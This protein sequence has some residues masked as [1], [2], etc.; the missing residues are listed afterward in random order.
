MPSWHD[1]FSYPTASMDKHRLVS[2]SEGQNVI[3][4][5]NK[6]ITTVMG[7]TYI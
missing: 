2:A 6:Q 5:E 7:I 4:Q 3:T 1:N